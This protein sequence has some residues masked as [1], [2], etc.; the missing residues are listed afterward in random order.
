MYYKIKKAVCETIVNEESKTLANRIFYICIITLILLNIIL[1]AI[2]T[3]GSI[4]VNYF[5]F[6]VGFDISIIFIFTIE[7][8]LRIWSCNID[9]RFKGRFG[10]LR[11]ARQPIIIIDLLAILPFYIV[12]FTPLD[13]GYAMIGRLLR[14]A[15]LFRF[16]FF[17]RALKVMITAIRRKN[18]ELLIT[19]IVVVIL[20]I[21]CAYIIYAAENRAQ[22]E[23]Y[24]SIPKSI[25]WSF[26]T[27][28]TVGYGDMTPITPFGRFFTAIVA[29]LGVGIIAIPAGI[30]S[31]GM[32]EIM[33]DIKTAGIKKETENISRVKQKC[34]HCGKSIDNA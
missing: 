12:Y 5:K 11:Y 27:M 26:V 4:S 13:N 10:R 18:R 7:Y 19:V 21:F 30:I 29:F 22:P 6:I 28:S 20:V 34:P 14:L 33:R 3:I 32:T 24:S 17:A 31:S 16:G 23:V 15:R 9:E 25:Y 1:V 2:S 8:I